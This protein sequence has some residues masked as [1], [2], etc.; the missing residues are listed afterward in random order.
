MIRFKT[1]KQFKPEVT[2]EIALILIS[3]SL[4]CLL[5][6]TQG[7]KLVV[8]NLFYLPVVLAGFFLGRYRAG[9]LTLLCIMTASIATTL[10]MDEFA[11]SVTPLSVALA[12]TVWGAV[13]GLTALLVGTLS[14]EKT[15]QCR[16][17]HD[18]YLGIMEVLSE[19]LSSA[20]PRR[21]F[22]AERITRLSIEVGR[23]LR[24]SDKQVDDLRV[25]SLLQNL[26][27]VEITARV[28]RRA[29]DSL[30]TGGVST[31]QH[32]FHGSDLVQSLATVVSGALPLLCCGDGSLSSTGPELHSAASVDVA[33]SAQILRAVRAYVASESSVSAGDISQVALVDDLRHDEGLACHGSIFDAL[34]IVLRRQEPSTPETLEMAVS[35]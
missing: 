29:V 30:D 8:L 2:L 23:Q 22:R 17:L 11:I 4:M 6:R 34:E 20:D 35:G 24:F 18:A 3:I 1:M 21:Q 15:K 13:L 28:I 10:S 33:L 7:G 5:Y 9:V 16:E 26:E 25:A 14:D 32:T 27:N 19:Y 31:A 12:I